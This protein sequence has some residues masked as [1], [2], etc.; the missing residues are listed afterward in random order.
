MHF[1]IMAKILE[2]PFINT[3]KCNTLS[4]T[5]FN[6]LL[7]SSTIPNMF[8]WIE[9]LLILKCSLIW[10]Y[11]ASTILKTAIIQEER[12]ISF[13]FMWPFWHK[14]NYLECLLAMEW[15]Y[16]L[17]IKALFSFLSHLEFVWVDDFIWS[18]LVPL[19]L[20]IRCWY[21]LQ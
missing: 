2:S 3:S 17:F 18:K 8:F 6:I 5:Y 14:S 7:D 15:Y 11:L 21:T 16:Y 1:I 12:T 13:K 4:K 10:F 20:C 19:R 9:R